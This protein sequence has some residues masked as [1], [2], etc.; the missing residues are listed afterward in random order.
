M[1]WMRQAGIGVVILSWW[2][3]GSFEDNR[4]WDLLDAAD[5]YG[6]RVSFYVEP[7]RR[8][9]KSERNANGT[10]SP[11]T[12]RDDVKY[13]MD[14]YG[15]HRALHRIDG[16]PVF[17]FFAAR[18]YM[19]GSQENWKLVW[20]EVHLNARY[21]PIVIAHDINLRSRISPGGWDGGHAYG[22]QEALSQNANWKN[23][24]K[25]YLEA[26]KLFFF[27]VSPGYDK[28]RM[29][30]GTD[31]IVSRRNG[32]LY[33]DMW[34]KAIR[35]RLTSSR[36]LITSFNEWHEGTSIEPV[37]PMSISNY[38]YRDYE[39]HFGMTGMNASM[40]YVAMTRAFSNRFL[41]TVK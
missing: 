30:P 41:T 5:D 37:V 13:I 36:V 12:A 2:G 34:K 22:I 27:T 7:Y 31:P 15:C 9:Y 40:S 11:F 19:A 20:D 8:G 10:R 35:S 32:K 26:K 1:A 6:L 14:L 25:Q 29:S 23:L 39:G 21:N 28:T 3:Q 18:E 4:V 24:A 17:F 38:T 33:R 16:R